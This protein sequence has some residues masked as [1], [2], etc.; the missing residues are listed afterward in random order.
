M[1]WN[2]FKISSDY[3]EIIDTCFSGKELET[4]KISWWLEPFND[5]NDRNKT[6]D[7]KIDYIYD[8]IVK[9]WNGPKQFQVPF[10]SCITNLINA[11]KNS[12]SI[13]DPTIVANVYIAIA[14]RL[15]QEELIA[16]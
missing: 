10:P 1:G 4:E 11:L 15:A 13:D 2:K 12:T 3:A 5:D 8:Q 6:N 16:A 9:E 14:N 7:E